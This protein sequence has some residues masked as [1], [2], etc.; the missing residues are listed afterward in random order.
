[1]KHLYQLRML[2]RFRD[3]ARVVLRYSYSVLNPL[4]VYRKY[5]AGP[6]RHLLGM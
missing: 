5:G 3:R 4:H 6:L 1:M 2:E